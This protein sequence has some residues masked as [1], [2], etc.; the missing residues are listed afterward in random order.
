MRKQWVIVLILLLTSR[1]TLAQNS[2]MPFTVIGSFSDKNFNSSIDYI[3]KSSQTLLNSTTKV[4]K[5]RFKIK[6][7][8][9][10]PQLITIKISM[11][12]KFKIYQFYI[13]PNKKIYFQGISETSDF[14]IKNSDI[15]DDKRKLEYQKN[16]I[17]QKIKEIEHLDNTNNQTNLNIRLALIDSL[18]KIDSLFILKNCSSYYASILLNKY[19][20][21]PKLLFNFSSFED[22]YNAYPNYLKQTSMGLFLKDYIRLHSLLNHEAPTFIGKNANNELINSSDFFNGNITLLCFSATWC[23][24]CEET[25]KELKV[26]FERYNTNNHFRL[27]SLYCDSDSLQWN[28]H[29]KQLPWTTLLDK[30]GLAN[31]KSNSIFTKYKIQTLPTLM[32]INP[33]GIITY[34]FK[35]HKFESLIKNIEFE[36]N[37]NKISTISN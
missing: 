32:I 5:G 8:I 15:E 27:V 4:L 10:E 31:P 35:D 14:T 36:L 16:E 9:T 23:I 20:K 22:I 25:E 34:I 13:E 19:L 11:N 17:N 18:R 7:T 29:V 1:L 28:N 12:S 24:P 3:I 30:D 37:N 21:V 6:G 2:E 33:Q 26:L